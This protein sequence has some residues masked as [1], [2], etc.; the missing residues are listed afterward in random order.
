M[1]SVLRL[2]LPL[3][4][5]S[6]LHLEYR[7]MRSVQHKVA[8]RVLVASALTIH[9]F[10]LDRCRT[11]SHQQAYLISTSFPDMSHDKEICCRRRLTRIS[12]AKSFR[13][14]IPIQPV[15]YSYITRR[16]PLHHHHHRAGSHH[17]HRSLV[18]IRK[19]TVIANE[20]CF[21]HQMQV[22]PHSALSSRRSP[23]A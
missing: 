3:A 17:H 15:W 16:H 19:R 5:V 23:L 10:A 13:Q 18:R 1:I 8:Y 2:T 22:G 4:S 11:R 6:T 7:L 14:G 12:T 20:T 21:H 9:L